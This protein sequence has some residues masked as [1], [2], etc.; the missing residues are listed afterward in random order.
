MTAN[1]ISKQLQQYLRAFPERGNYD[2]EV[3]TNFKPEKAIYG[4]VTINNMTDRQCFLYMDTAREK[5]V[6]S[7]FDK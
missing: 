7:V 6:L 1:E 2:F 5:M 3:E 4:L